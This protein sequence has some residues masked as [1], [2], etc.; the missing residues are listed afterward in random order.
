MGKY[1]NTFGVFIC[2]KWYKIQPEPITEAKG[3]TIPWD[4]AVQIDRNIKSN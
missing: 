4:L 1:E 2:E 3:T